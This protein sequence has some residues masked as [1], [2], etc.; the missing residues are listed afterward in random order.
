MALRT[1]VLVA[2]VGTP[3]EGRPGHT[4][5][6][7]QTFLDATFA[8]VLT[9][10]LFFPAKAVTLVDRTVGPVVVLAYKTTFFSARVLVAVKRT[11]RP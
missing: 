11:R 1:S 3:V 4:T 2:I 7:R 8:I 6:Q 5:V 10:G 9:W